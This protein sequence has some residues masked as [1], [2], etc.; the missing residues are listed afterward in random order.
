M[1]KTMTSQHTARRWLAVCLV[2]FL[3]MPS[4]N[5]AAIDPGSVKGKLT[6]KG[7]VY[8]SH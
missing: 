5:A 3:G 4:M 2:I 6:H 7:K 1:E 8:P